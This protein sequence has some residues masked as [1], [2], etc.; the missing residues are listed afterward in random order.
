MN[1]A[2]KAETLQRPVADRHAM[3]SGPGHWCGDRQLARYG[4]RSAEMWAEMC[5]RIAGGA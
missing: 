2:G 4:L 5:E 1:S 3:H